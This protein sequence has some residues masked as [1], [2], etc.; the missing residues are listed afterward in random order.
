MIADQ[1]YDDYIELHVKRETAVRV[2]CMK[3]LLT[4]LK[5]LVFDYRRFR[6]IFDERVL[7]DPVG[8]WVWAMRILRKLDSLIWR[9]L[10]YHEVEV[11][12]DSHVAVFRRLN[13]RLGPARFVVNSVRGATALGITNPNSRSNAFNTFA[14]YLKQTRCHELIFC[15][16]EVDCGFLIWFLAEKR[17][18]AVNS[19]LNDA[20][21]SYTQFI[22][23]FRGS[24]RIVVLSA[25][26]PTIPDGFNTGE[27]AN[28]RREVSVSQT[29]RTKLT[30]E[31]NRRIKSWCD[32]NEA[33]FVDLDSVSLDENTGAVRKCLLNAN[34]ADHHYCPEQYIQLLETSSLAGFYG[35]GRNLN[36][37]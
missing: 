7:N 13:G 32:R 17:Q 2:R 27:I 11:Y 9:V 3:R 15:L 28:L 25:P 1:F 26:L 20:V 36:K 29:Q 10:G 8:R 33:V 16:G 6:G 34:P 23:Q 14:K 31:F 5:L 12:G 37:A 35:N 19:L 21:N 18:Q 30:L 4:T 22:A 24:R